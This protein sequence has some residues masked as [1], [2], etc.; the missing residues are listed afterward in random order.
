MPFFPFVLLLDSRPFSITENMILVCDKC[1]ASFLVPASLFVGGPRIVRCARCG[2]TW[3]A[4]PN[5]KAPP[6][7]PRAAPPPL[8]SFTPLPPETSSPFEIAPPPPKEKIPL[9]IRL[10]SFLEPLKRLP[11]GK[12][13][14]WLSGSAAV[15][16]LA[17]SLVFVFGHD[18]IVQRWPEMQRYYIA[19]GLVTEAPAEKLVLRNVK[20]ERRYMDGAMHLTIGGEIASQA[21]KTQVIPPLLA[22]AIGP[23][24]QVIQSWQIEPPEATLRPGASAVFSSAILS[25]EGT[26]VEINLSFVEPPHDQP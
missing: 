10:R 24:G 17:G 19:L 16:S 13:S 20:S 14:L 9:Q 5:E 2:N 23:D 26:V 25:P 4:D 18:P 21:K 8:H 12:I 15:L 6:P 3:L 11:W 7:P 1:K 22:E